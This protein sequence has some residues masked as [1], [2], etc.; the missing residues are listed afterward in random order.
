MTRE[1]EPE[2]YAAFAVLA[3]VMPLLLAAEFVKS[4]VLSFHLLAI[5]LWGL[6]IVLSLVLSASLRTGMITMKGMRTERRYEPGIYWFLIF[7]EV[8]LLAVLILTILT[9]PLWGRR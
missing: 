3:L 5:A 9:N 7:A 2:H 1:W 8:S 6:P 4:R